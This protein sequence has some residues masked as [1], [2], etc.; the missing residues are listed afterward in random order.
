MKKNQQK[1]QLDI[2][3]GNGDVPTH[4]SIKHILKH[5]SSFICLDGGADKLNSLDYEPNIILGDLDSIQGSYKCRTIKLEDQ[6][7]SDLEK[8]ILWCLENNFSE[9]SLVGFSGGRGDHEFLTLLIM[10]KYAEKIRL[11]LYTN[12]S[13]VEC[14][15]NKTLFPS[16]PNQVIS[17]ISPKADT[18]ITTSDLKYTLS[19][20]K[21]SNLS[22]GISNL[23]MGESYSI[24]SSD[25]V[26]V[27][28][29]YPS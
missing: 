27:F 13:K 1:T 22:E 14:V 2:L 15:K 21:L 26:W 18:L 17:I 19:N 4:N 16:S 11:T 5:A 12:L 6:S 8:G 23:T 7:K 24:E 9:L 28:E 3:F 29:N 20:E 10:L 25:W